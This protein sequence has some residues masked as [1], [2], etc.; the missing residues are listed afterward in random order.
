M[1]KPLLYI[2]ALFLIV[3][4]LAF[5][6][7]ID[8][9]RANYT[10]Y[11]YEIPMRDGKKLFTA[12]YVPKDQSQSYPIMLT[13]S[14]YSVA[15]YGV[16]HY[17]AS[18]GP[19]ESFAKDGFVFAYQDVRGRYMSEGEWMEVRPHKPVK[20]GPADTDEST[21]TYDTV[22]WLIKHIKNNNGKVGM[23]GSRTSASTP[24]PGSSTPIRR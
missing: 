3:S 9:I 10:K 18:L 7:G 14:P 21:D 5:G 24:Q 11:E 4:N 1:K 6:Q 13:R 17:P 20:T 12:V 8:Y 15:P 23:W 2:A 22:D 19:S 16:D